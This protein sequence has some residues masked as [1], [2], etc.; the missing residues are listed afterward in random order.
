MA[1][2]LEDRLKKALA[3]RKDFDLS[4]FQFLSL[5]MVKVG[6]GN[7]WIPLRK[8]I[9]Q[10]A[11]HFVE[12]RLHADDVLV[13]CRGGF[14]LIFAN[15]DGYRAKERAANL[16]EELNLFFLG[17][18]ILKD[19]E[20][21]SGTRTVNAE[22]LQNFISAT[23]AQSEE[24]EEPEEGRRRADEDKRSRANTAWK[25]LSHDGKTARPGAL[26]E[27]GRGGTDETKTWIGQSGKRCADAN[28]AGGDDASEAPSDMS[29]EAPG[30]DGA[31]NPASGKPGKSSLPQA[32]QGAKAPKPAAKPA[33]A[34]V[35][36]AAA[37]G[38]VDAVFKEENGH[39]DDIVF[40]PC[41][42]AKNGIIATNFCLPRKFSH[43]KVFYGRDTLMGADSADLHRYLD[44]EVAVAAQ[45]GFQNR[46]TEGSTCAIAIPVHYDTI[47][48]VSDRVSY[49]SIL[50]HVPQHLRRYF[51]C[52]SMTFPRARR[53]PKCRNYS[54]R[55]PVSGP[56]CWPT[57]PSEPPT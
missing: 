43:G 5:E 1:S 17:D 6:S 38:L 9:Y 35:S 13:R 31:E 4:Q 37:L 52:G 24:P 11:A 19:L 28:W 22:D 57:S 2:G 23:Q 33:P 50:Q 34:A 32:S 27:S 14:I 47:S 56:M 12:K 41:W 3:G 30:W 29:V 51:S 21:R 26:S 49:F 44:H 20:I 48:V 15:L 7:Q 10:V 8:K 39:W 16:S 36:Q 25:D 40:K 18:Q 45:R 54:G 42:D 53:S 46:Y 55:W